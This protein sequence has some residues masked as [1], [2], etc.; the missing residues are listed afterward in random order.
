MVKKVSVELSLREARVVLRA[1]Q[2][3]QHIT[4]NDGLGVDWSQQSAE[5]QALCDAEYEIK[6]G[7]A[8]MAKSIGFAFGS[9]FRLAQKWCGEKPNTALPCPRKAVA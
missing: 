5:W 6:L 7:V 4:H 8:T 2:V 1:L 3:A 9:G